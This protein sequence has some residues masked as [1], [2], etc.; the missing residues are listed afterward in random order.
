MR[1]PRYIDDHLV[2]LISL[3]IIFFVPQANSAMTDW[4]TSSTLTFEPYL[5]PPPP[6]DIISGTS[7]EYMWY[8]QGNVTNCSGDQGPNQVEFRY[9]FTLPANVFKP[10]V[11]A[12]I[13]LLADDYFSLYVNGALKGY[14]WL[15]DSTNATTPVSFD[16]ASDLKLG[17]ANEILIFACNGYPPSPRI[18]AGSTPAGG[19][20]GCTSP[21]TR[22]NNWLLVDGGITVSPDSG[23]GNPIYQT[24]LRSGEPSNWEVR[25]VPEP[26]SILLIGLGFSTIFTARKSR[27]V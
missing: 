1:T 4:T 21:S 19:W 22:F 16:I 18:S 15:D 8:C 23:F 11:V 12:N 10:Y 6:D 3:M 9:Q 26:S 2:F 27:K 7:A 5:S 25:A 20:D 14:Q 24:S 17:Q 13:T